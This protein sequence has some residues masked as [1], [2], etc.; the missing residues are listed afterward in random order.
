VQLKTLLALAV[1][2]ACAADA[3]PPPTT[4][5]IAS[6]AATT[7]L[8]V[9]AWDVGV[10][11]DRAHVIGRGADNGEL[12]VVDVRQDGPDRVVVTGDHDLAL[13]STGAVAADTADARALGAVLY[14]DLGHVTRAFARPI[15][16]GLGEATSAVS[17][18]SS[19][20]FQIGWSMFGSN[21]TVDVSTFCSGQVRSDASYARTT[22]QIAQCS[23][24]WESPIVSDCRA[25]VSFAI[26]GWHWDVCNWYVEVQ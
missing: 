3:P 13:T 11:G 22:Y 15:G 18:W 26:P 20:S 16:D 14:A 23:L 5:L 1:L 24:D 9:I 12:V 2:P 10:D 6:N 19:G 4:S 25:A 17:T 8:G 7:E 21:G